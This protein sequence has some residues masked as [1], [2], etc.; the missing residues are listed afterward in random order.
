M[1]RP[2]YLDT[3]KISASRIINLPSF[4]FFWASAQFN[5]PIQGSS[6]STT[7]ITPR[8]Y[9]SHC[10]GKWKSSLRCL[11]RSSLSVL[12][13]QTGSTFQQ[14]WV[15][16]RQNHY[17]VVILDYTRHLTVHPLNRRTMLQQQRQHQQRQTPAL[18]VK[19][20]KVGPSIPY[21]QLTI[22]VLKES[23]T[24]ENRVSL[25]PSNV[26]MLVDAGLKVVV[27]TGGKD[28]PC[29][30][31]FSLLSICDVNCKYYCWYMRPSY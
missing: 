17:I 11:S 21:T 12:I 26:K 20:M 29:K 1:R 28:V 9:V 2:T 10:L 23:Y 19:G 7:N 13:R 8:R 16:I 27:E 6:R 30:L 18:L 15:I 14:L 4:C 31:I 24:G 3:P 22:G 25:A 5:L